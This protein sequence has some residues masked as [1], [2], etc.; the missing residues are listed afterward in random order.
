MFPFAL[1]RSKR[2]LLAKGKGLPTCA[3]D[4]A[5]NVATVIVEQRLSINDGVVLDRALL[6]QVPRVDG[7]IAEVG[8]EIAAVEQRI[9]DN[10]ARIANSNAKR[11]QYY[12]YCN[13]TDFQHDPVSI[14]VS[15]VHAR[16]FLSTRYSPHSWLL[17]VDGEPFD[18]ATE[19]DSG[20][21][22]NASVGSV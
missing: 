20:P 8:E 14:K 10:Q 9:R 22:Y 1:R 18:G 11:S 13:A 2:S 12:A 21:F 3:R 17:K 15:P 7:R 5:E 4:Y 16:V 19:A 6:W